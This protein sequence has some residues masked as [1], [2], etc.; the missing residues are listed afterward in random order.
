MTRLFDLMQ[1]RKLLWG[2]NGLFS[3]SEPPARHRLALVAISLLCFVPSIFRGMIDPDETRYAEITREMIESGDWIVPHLN[4]VPYFMK[5]PLVYWLAALSVQVLGFHYWV[6]RLAPMLA[7]ILGIL[8]TYEMGAALGSRRSG[9]AAAA[10]LLT[11]GLYYSMGVFFLTDMIFSAFLF[12]AWWAFWRYYQ[13]GGQGAAWMVLF[14][15]C[16]SLACF[17]KGPLGPAL[18]VFTIGL[19]LLLRRDLLFLLK[20]KLGIG[21]AIFIFINAP[22]MILIYRRDP[23]FLEFFYLQV[24]AAGVRGAA[25]QHPE[26]FYY[27]FYVLPFMMFPWTIPAVIALVGSVRRFAVLAWRAV[28]RKTAIEPL[29]DAWLDSLFVGGFV[30]LSIPSAKLSTYILPVFMSAA[31]LTARYLMQLDRRSAVT[32]VL[33]P[34]QC[35]AI[36]VGALVFGGLGLADRLRFSIFSLNLWAVVPIFAVSLAIFGYAA[37]MGWKGE[38]GRLLLAMGLAMAVMSPA[39]MNCVPKVAENQSVEGL[40]APYKEFLETADV[41]ATT[42]SKT[43]SLPLTLRR[44][45]VIVGRARELGMGLFTQNI[46]DKPIPDD[47]FR[48]R[49]GDLPTSYLLSSQALENLWKTTQTVCLFASERYVD[50]FL[51]EHPDVWILNENEGK[52]QNTWILGNNGELMLLTNRNPALLARR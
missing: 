8:V 1:L 34:L 50:D 17:T 7:A 24:N 42:E 25:L 28:R 44:R 38:R 32:R 23:R 13:G 3:E 4:Y 31:L 19:F 15:L 51:S 27:Y 46:P 6:M 21:I 48:I 10:I 5:P 18:L 52:P 39:A 26:P 20:M 33:L 11:T 37:W 2:E 49:G 22:W 12:G 30:L 40:C 35:A 16:G 45:I 9:L 36:I 47:P 14:W 43:F 29:N 41:I